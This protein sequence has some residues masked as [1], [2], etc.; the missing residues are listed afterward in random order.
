MLSQHMRHDLASQAKR[1]ATDGGINACAALQELHALVELFWRKLLRDSSNAWRT[2][3]VHMART[4][5]TWTPGSVI[6]LGVIGHSNDGRCVVCVCPAAT[7]DSVSVS[8]G[9]CAFKHTS[10]ISS[11]GHDAVEQ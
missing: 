2:Y 5:A 10:P 1:L 9:R 11:G 6:T 8:P 4:H 7:F 3:G